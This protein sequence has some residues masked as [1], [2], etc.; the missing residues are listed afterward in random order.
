M[1]CI[2]LYRGQGTK[3]PTK[4]RILI[5]CRVPFS[6]Y[7][8]LINNRIKWYISANKQVKRAAVKC[9]C[10]KGTDSEGSSEAVDARCSLMLTRNLNTQTHKHTHRHT[11]THIGMVEV[12][13]SVLPCATVCNF[14]PA[15]QA[16]CREDQGHGGP[17]HGDFASSDQ[18]ARSKGTLQTFQPPFS[19]LLVGHHQELKAAIKKAA[20]KPKAKKPETEDGLAQTM[21]A[22]RR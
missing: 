13:I 15:A 10:M 12:S 2:S 8:L 4:G 1:P 19:W 11:H 6:R 16:Q 7:S 5:A 20:A 18:E 21:T 9:A 14:S 3:L 17:Q 22:W